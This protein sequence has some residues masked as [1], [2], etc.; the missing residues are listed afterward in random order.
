MTEKLLDSV[1]STR[2]RLARNV[3]GIPFPS[4]MSARHA[5]TVSDKV[6]SALGSGYE[7]YTLKGMD[8]M[9]IGALVERHLISKELMNS[10]F[11]SVAVDTDETVSVMTGEEDHVR[12]QVILPGYALESAYE[13][14]NQIDNI[15]SREVEYAF[16]QKLGYLTA[17]PTNLGTGMRASVMLFLPALTL[18]DTIKRNVRALS[19][20]NIT[21]R[22]VYG[23]GSDALGHV[24]Q[25][26]NR[27]SLGISEYEILT[28]VSSAVDRLI[29]EEAR[30]RDFLIK[31]RESA[32]KDEIMRA[33]GIVT[34]A[35]MLTTDEV[36]RYCALVK[37]GAYYG[38][39]PVVDVPTIDEL[40]TKMQPYNLV[41][42]ISGRL[43]SAEARDICRAEE[44]RKV[45]S[46]IVKR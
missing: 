41:T 8:E 40:V 34:N 20:M 9:D 7:I 11:G 39:V 44:V 32:L 5:S 3:K 37:L 23:E 18:T 10:P 45:F 35:Y 26:S 17:C 46:T 28:L 15:I 22:G 43:A 33:Y 2:I 29:S 19:S 6:Y 25:I 30:A 27:C 42:R 4:K 31:E 13:R 1:I 16:D 12:Q 24:Y 14:A 21:V 38:I 36:L